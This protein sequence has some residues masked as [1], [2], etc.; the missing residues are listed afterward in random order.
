MNLFSEIASSAT[1]YDSD[2]NL[3][4]CKMFDKSIICFKEDFFPTKYG[5]VKISMLSK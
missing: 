1:Y 4:S 5:S 2:Q 3:Y